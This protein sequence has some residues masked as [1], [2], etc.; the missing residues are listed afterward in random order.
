MIEQYEKE[1]RKQV[2]IM[3][4]ITNYGMGVFFFCLGVFFFIYERLGIDIGAKPSA[5]DK[6]IGV[7]FVSYGAWRIYRGYKKS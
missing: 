6:V 1:R 4:A 7:L 5:L 2:S 3:R